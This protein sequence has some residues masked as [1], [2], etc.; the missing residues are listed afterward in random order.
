MADWLTRGCWALW[1]HRC[2]RDV[3]HFRAALK[4]PEAAQAAQLRSILRLAEGSQWAKKFGMNQATTLEDF[5]ARVPV[6]DPPRLTVWTDRIMRGETQVLS[7]A[8]L[9]R[10]VPTS[11]TTGPSK[12]IPMNRESRREYAI[13]VNLW[14]HDCL[15]QC[16]AIMNGR[17]YIATSPA[18][19]PEPNESAVP[20]GFA[21]DSAYLGY[22]EARL[23]NRILAVPTQ[24]TQQ[25]GTAWRNAT[26]EHLFQ[27]SDLRFL[28]LWHPGYLEALFEPQEFAELRKRWKNLSLISCWSDGAC[29]QQ[30]DHLMA[31][32]P[33]ARHHPKGLW[34]TEGAVTVPLGTHRPIALNSGFFEFEAADGT[35]L[36]A[37]QLDRNAHYRPILSNHAGLYRYRL[38]DKVRVD[39]HIGH[40]PSLHW[41]GRADRVIDICGEKLSD[42]QIA[43]ALG[44]VGWKQA[45]RIAPI[46]DEH[47][48]YYRCLVNE[49]ASKFPIQAFETALRRNPHYNWARQIGQL[50]PL[51]VQAV[52]QSSLA[53]P[54]TADQPQQKVLYLCE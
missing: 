53:E 5:R 46:R 4:N 13:A 48:P 11:G 18:I 52:I 35:I 7:R 3:R 9:E 20:I 17:A 54:I 10:L 1:R 29:R 28:S 16:P 33:R 14:L 6:Q 47:P 38:G 25:R 45:F 22:W 15:A 49:T 27:A 41:V 19:D 37:H 36:L 12:L 30:C 39:G 8:P 40:T 43:I 31:H 42:A 2:R 21:A 24:V 50:A 34:L 32:F 51:H 26:R 44:A 23:L